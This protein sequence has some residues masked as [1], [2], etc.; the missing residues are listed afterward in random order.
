VSLSELNLRGEKGGFHKGM[1]RNEAVLVGAGAARA[2]RP[3]NGHHIPASR[4][5]V[6]QT[7]KEQTE[8]TLVHSYAILR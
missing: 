6:E 8:L 1:A 3:P 5:H 7:R 4:K 2:W